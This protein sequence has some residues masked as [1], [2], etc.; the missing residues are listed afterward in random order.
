MKRLLLFLSLSLLLLA[1]FSLFSQGT[2]K[3]KITDS[4]SGEGMLQARIVVVG[5]QTGAL[6]DFDGNFEFKVPKNPPFTLRVTYVSYDTLDYEVSTFDKNHKLKMKK[7]EVTTNV[8]EIIGQSITEKDKKN[9]LT[10]ESLGTAAIKE[11]AGPDFY[12][13]LGNLKGVDLTSASLGFKII[14]TRGFNSTSPVRSLQIIDGVDN[15]SPGL[16]FSLGNFLG[17]SDLDVQRVDLVVG[18]SSA[19]YGPN[20]FNGVI[21]MTTK[22]PFDHPGLSVQG[23]I[24]ERN[25]V[26]GAVRYAHIFYNKED[27]PKFAFKVNGFFMRADDWEATNLDPTP[28]SEVGLL[29]PGD[30]D[31]VNRYGDEN[32]TNANDATSLSQQVNFPGLGIFHRTGYE[33]R[34]IVDY[35]TENV[36]LGASMH[37]RFTDSLEFIAASNFGTGTTVYQGD[38]RYSLK[39]ILFFQHRVELKATD[40]GFIRAYMTHEDAGKS[41]DGVFTAFLLNEASRSDAEWGR[42]YRNYWTFNINNRV[43]NLPGMPAF[44]FPYDYDRADSVL[45]ANQDS[46]IAWHQE[47]RDTINAGWTN[48]GLVDARYEPGTARY[49]SLLN[50]ITSKTSFTEGGTR[51]YDRSKLYH[52]HAEYKFTP[53]FMDITVGANGR[54]YTPDS[55]GTIFQEFVVTE[56]EPFQYDTLLT[57]ITNWEVGSYIGFEKKFIDER[58]KV[59]LTARV[60]KN[61]NFKPLVSPAASA[62]FNANQN[63]ILR[64]SFSSA[65]R[66]PTLTEQYL[67]YNVGRAILLGNVNGIDSLVTIPSLITFFSEQV[68]DSLQWFDVPPIRPEKVRSIELGYR[69]TLWDQVYVDAS[70]Y[71]SYYKDFLGFKVGGVI[72]YNSTFNRATLEQVYRV[73]ANADDAVTTQG[74]SIGANWYFKDYYALTGNYSWNRLNKLGTDDPI[75]PAFNTPEHKFNLGIS[76]RNIRIKLGEEKE[77]KDWG[78][79]VNYKWVEGFQFEGS[80]Q[81]TG[82]V[83]TYSLLDAQINKTIPKIHTTFKL[84]GSNLISKKQLQVYGGPYIG[85]MVYFQATVELGDL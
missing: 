84:G 40:K 78:F 11:V 68:F 47:V 38:N 35:G 22:S 85:R 18:A 75:I 39:D 62:V 24:G 1:P 57:P 10:V 42:D 70:Y 60:D 43:R 72:D 13:S 49:D 20:A 21:S 77:L 34:N 67:N 19:F 50:D 23:K 15:Q 16:N 8:V 79:N 83:P 37:Y 53:A 5:T 7:K 45:A 61:Q 66:N 65:I 76:G 26:Q 17:A 33:E 54:L 73:A 80:P 46:L 2:V 4:E 82:F 3:G 58:L 52:V 29:N 51:L 25:L 63:H 9:P 69:G 36:K 6:T 41:Y 32:I 28:Q 48:L 56:P 14:N 59:N 31:A 64:L 81:F 27:E 55:D 30:Y 12:A 74:F 44:A 71:F